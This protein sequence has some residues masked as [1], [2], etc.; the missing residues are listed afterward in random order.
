TSRKTNSGQNGVWVYEIGSSP[1]FFAI[2]PGLVTSLPENATEP[3]VT[4]LPRQPDEAQLLPGEKD[5]FLTEIPHRPRNPETETVT[6]GFFEPETEE[7]DYPEYHESETFT[8]P[9]TEPERAQ[10]RYPD[11]SEPRYPDRTETR[12]PEPFQPR[13]TAPE[14]TEPPYSPVEP[15]YPDPV[16]PRYTHPHSVQPV[17]PHSRPQQPQIV[18]VDEHLDVN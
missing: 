13:Y 18:V 16:Q 2:T 9:Y 11:P 15:G 12:Y 14:P 1:F 4:M 17:P 6:P 10:P 5:E 3:P 8:P 7:P